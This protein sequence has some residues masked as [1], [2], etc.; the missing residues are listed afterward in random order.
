[1]LPRGPGNTIYRRDS[2]NSY[3]PDIE[4]VNSL[5][6]YSDNRGIGGRSKL[7]SL[8][9]AGCDYRVTSQQQVV[10]LQP[11]NHRCVPGQVPVTKP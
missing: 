7:V 11:Y 9:I 6:R 1:M 8:V 3:P 10:S 5:H 4:T 2:G